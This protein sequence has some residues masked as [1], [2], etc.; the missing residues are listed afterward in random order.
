[1]LI[2]LLYKSCNICFSN[3]YNTLNT[4]ISNIIIRIKK[5]TPSVSYIIDLFIDKQLN[6]TIHQL[7]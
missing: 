7:R 5:I 2:L 1:M 3:N 4:H 6:Y